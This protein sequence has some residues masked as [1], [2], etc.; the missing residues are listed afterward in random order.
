MPDS[1]KRFRTVFSSGWIDIGTSW[2]VNEVIGRAQKLQVE[3]S[4]MT[5]D[6]FGC[7]IIFQTLFENAHHAINIEEFESQ[8]SPTGGI[9][10]VGAVALGQAKQL[11]GGTEAAPGKLTRQQLIGEVPDGWS[12][13]TSSLA[14]EV[15][16]AHGVRSFSVGIIV[17]I[18]RAPA[19]RLALMGFDQLAV[20]IDADQRAICTDLNLRTGN[21]TRR[22]RIQRAINTDMLIGM[23]LTVGPVRRIKAPA[24]ER[25]QNRF[26]F[27][28]ENLDR[29][30][31][32]G[33]MD[34]A[35]GGIPAPDQSST[36][37]V[38][39]IDKRFTFEET[40]PDKTHGI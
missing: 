32:G 36:R 17:V 20:N 5:G 37:D 35:A 38:A 40:L 15:G 1:F 12:K 26:F 6:G 31:A 9:Q 30:S 16:P 28:L 23:N 27:A 34:A 18:G 19:A 25:N 24:L 22:D 7:G 39:Q 11:L 13:L 33:S 3:R 21:P 4:L 8:R 29:Y 14:V 2:S 10:S